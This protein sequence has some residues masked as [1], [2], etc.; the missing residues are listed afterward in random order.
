ME[1]VEARPHANLKLH[2]KISGREKK[3]K[4][5]DI[6]ILSIFFPYFTETNLFLLHKYLISLFMMNEYHKGETNRKFYVSEISASY[7]Y[8]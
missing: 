2:E 5:N 6:N 8:V 4:V 7:F 3:G 1:N